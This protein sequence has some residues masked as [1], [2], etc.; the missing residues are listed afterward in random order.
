MVEI[1]F[2]Y[3]FLIRNEIADGFIEYLGR[4]G[5][6]RLPAVGALHCPVSVLHYNL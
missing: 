3:L 5:L 4:A 6:E 2:T 1:F